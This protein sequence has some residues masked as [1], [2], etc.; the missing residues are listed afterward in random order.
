M[1]APKGEES[2]RISVDLPISLIEKFDKLKV[3]WGYR[4]RGDV[5]ERLLEE[6]LPEDEKMEVSLDLDPK[7][8]KFGDLYTDNFNQTESFNE[9]RALVLIDST[10]KEYS[11]E[12]IDGN[13]NND[14]DNASKSSK[15]GI[16]LPGFVQKRTSS[17]KKSLSDT[18]KLPRKEDL[19]NNFVRSKDIKEALIE[20]QKHWLSLY[21]NQPKENVVEAAMLW[22]G[23]D[24][25][26]SLDIADQYSFTWTI[27]NKTMNEYCEE[28]EYKTPSLERIIVI[29]GVLEDPFASST[30]PSRVPTLIR[31]FVN[32]F[33]KSRKVTSFQTLESTMTVHGALK[34]LELPTTAGSALTLTKIRDAYKNKALKSHPD[35]GGST[36]IMRKINEAY[37][38]LKDLYRDK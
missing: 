30:L 32:K 8:N 31:R 23:R 34:M 27:A 25:W 2:R 1:A 3:E 38:L 19:I 11:I 12:T 24:I 21:G 28:W 4:A 9:S 35:A 14:T 29:A 18:A 10:E 33:K 22:L 5:L 7:N 37:Q 6:I 17:L 15:V 36:D 26:R 20:S 13:T 16:N